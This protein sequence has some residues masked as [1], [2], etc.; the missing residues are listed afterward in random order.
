MVGEQST[1]A[2]GT[3]EEIWACRRRKAPLLGKAR[4]R[5]ADH[6]RSIFLYACAASPRAELW[7]MRHILHGLQVA[8]PPAQAKHDGAP[9]AW[10]TGGGGK[11]LQ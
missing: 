8:V 3:Q 1:T 7:A 11:P 5:G 9:L 2:M 6:H 10:S 4:G